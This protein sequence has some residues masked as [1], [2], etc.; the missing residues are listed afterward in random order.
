MGV[1]NFKQGETIYKYEL[2]NKIGGGEFGEV[3]LA[4]DRSIGTQVAIKLLDGKNASVDERLI[5]AKIGNH[6]NHQN[7]NVI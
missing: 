1:F 2:Q 6:L 4:I 7:W 5:E 3:W